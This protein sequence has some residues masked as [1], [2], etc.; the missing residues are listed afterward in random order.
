MNCVEHKYG[1][2]ALIAYLNYVVIRVI[3]YEQV[4]KCVLDKLVDLNLSCRGDTWCELRYSCF[5]HVTH[6]QAIC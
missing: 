2:G 3:M 1:V 5:D 6:A 4:F